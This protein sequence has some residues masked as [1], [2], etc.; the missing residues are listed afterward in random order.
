MT[1]TYDVIIVGAG[2][3]G[4]IAAGV[5]AEAGKRVLL[6]ERGP[7]R[8]FEDVGR[9]HLRNQRLSLYGH[10]AGPDEEGN[11]RVVLDTQGREHLVRPHEGG[12][13]NNAAGVGGGTR[14]YGAQAW[15]FME[16]DFRMA[17]TYGV[18]EFSSLSDWPISYANLEPYYQRA[19]WE[20]GVSG[21]GEACTVQ[22][23]RAKAYPMPAVPDNPSRIVLKRGAEQLGWNTNPVPL[24]IN[25]APYLGRPACV[26]CSYCVGFACPSNSK[27]GTQNTLIPR[28][29]ATGQ[30]ELVIEA[31]AERIDTDANGKVVGVT[32]LIE[33]DGTMQRE[34]ATAKAVVVSSG[35][36]ESARLLLNS[37]STLHPQG[38]GNAHD[39]VGRSLQGHFYPGVQG[40]FEEVV[41][42]GLGPGVSIATSQFNHGNAGIVGG[43]MLAN[44]FTKLPMIFWR[45][46]I[47][48]EV[49]RWGAA[50]KR[51]MRENFNR[52]LHVMGPVQ[53][54]P[55]PE[56]RV[57]VA[58]EVRDRYGIPVAKL[59]GTTHPETVKT[60]TFMYERAREW[61]EASGATRVWG[62]P[63]SLGLSAGQHQAGTCRMGND[64]HTS[65]TDPWGRVHA[66]DNLFVVD[67]SLHV[68]N[69]GFN[70][71][72]TIMALAF[73]CAEHIAKVL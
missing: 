14:V 19:E 49:P 53:D 68:T 20:L 1:Q 33:R 17:S 45:G 31:M 38:L 71:V 73:R 21:D 48:P 29:L 60:A 65:V 37:A 43:G 26:Q 58:P 70:P 36:I 35:A 11:P 63:P 2:A 41:H 42:D 59:S 12:Y 64:P 28:A 5:L 72:L 30:C 13:Q 22:A 8:S 69:G 47:P 57:Q 51:W 62:Y 4:G 7:N 24:L 52:T 23:P 40:L 27:N 46:S 10:N 32:Y 25:T 54:I 44:E 39:I 16:Q 6:L 34:S 15:R 61:M 18:P 9:D 50:N 55:N 66:H 3:G 67:A 56:C